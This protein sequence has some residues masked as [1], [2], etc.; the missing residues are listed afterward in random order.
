MSAAAMDSG[1]LRL[2]LEELKRRRVVRAALAYIAAA[3]A[4]L[5]GAQPVFD[6]LLL[7]DLALRVLVLITI[8]CF[9]VVI[10]LAWVYELTADGIRRTPRAPRA[11]SAAPARRIP[12]RRRLQIAGLFVIALLFAAGTAAGLGRLRFPAAAEDGRVGL[13][14][15]PFRTAGNVDA[16]WSEGAADLLATALEGTA[17]LR[18]VDPWTLWRPL[19][20][21]A[22]ARADPPE[23]ER[24]AQLAAGIAAHRFMLGAVVANGARIDLTMRLYQVGRAD[25]IATFAIA[26]TAAGMVDV[27]RDV[28]I[29]VLSR[30][31]GL[32][33]PP[34]LP[35]ELDFDATHS[36]DALKAYLAAK[37]AM[38]RGSIDSANVAID[39]AIQLDS[40]FVLALTEAVTIK[41]WGSS[42]RGQ[43]YSGFSELLDRAEAFADSVN[44]RTRLR[45]AALRASVLT[46]GTRA[47]AAAR[48]I[49]EIDP[50]DFDASVTLGYYERAYGWQ[51]GVT[52][53]EGRDHAEAAVRLDTTYVPTLATRAWWALALTDTADQRIQLGRLERADTTSLLGHAWTAVLRASLASDSAFAVM[54]RTLAAAPAVERITLTRA[55]RTA[56]VDRAEAVW[57]AWAGTT[58]PNAILL[59]RTEQA[60]LQIVRG[61]AERVD[62]AIAAGALRENDQY[63]ALQLILVAASLAG[64]GDAAVTQR[65]VADLSA[66]VP[67]DSALTYFQ[68]RP[69]WWVGWLLGAYHAAAGDTTIARRWIQTIGTMPRGGLS[70]DY[71]GALQADIAARIAARRGDLETALQEALRAY[72]LWTIHAD[73]AAESMPAPN[74]RFHLGLLYRE[75]GQPDS[76]RAMFESLVPP[77]TWAGF[78]TA[79]ASFELGS[80]EQERGDNAM[81]V[82]HYNR[83]LQLWRDAGPGATAWL[84][85]TR[86]R[87]AALVS[88]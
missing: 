58:D 33:R 60:R 82:L 66:Y 40:T 34:E 52:R 74:M 35:A 46:D 76:A 77:T 12:W 14:I 86:D 85:Q 70:R 65:T 73:N 62:S 5:Q 44:P 37:E 43:P 69:A 9:P 25:P 78:L 8:A 3:F 6:G 75:L 41:S 21:A 72:E 18:I 88:R 67:P 56:R 54:L 13:A 81:A 30:V 22:D 26:G 50:S 57:R 7:P 59:A 80:L 42:T 39:R 10:A 23:L 87:M 51:F 11:G 79:R 49:L 38:R 19:R 61:H 71:V 15:F 48:R 24:A 32:R 28:A 36:P 83:A 2:L 63:R 45:I 47:A 31:W 4:L 20:P 64:L 53:L 16:A 55:L 27:V 1:R 29:R 68:T 17:G 84:Q